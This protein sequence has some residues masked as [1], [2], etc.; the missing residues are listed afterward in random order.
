MDSGLLTDF[1]GSDSINLFVTF[2]RN[3]LGAVCVNGMIAAF[4]EQMKAIFHS[5][6]VEKPRLRP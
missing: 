5:Q 6:G 4:P 3:N 2:D 1:V